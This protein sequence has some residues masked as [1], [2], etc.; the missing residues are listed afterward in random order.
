MLVKPNTHP[1]AG[2]VFGPSA[3]LALLGWHDVAANARDANR[4]TAII[5]FM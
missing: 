1:V 2:L 4:Q 5:F 3:R